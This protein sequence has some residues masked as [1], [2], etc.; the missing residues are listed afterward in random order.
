MI[1]AI[2][3][4]GLLVG[5][6]GENPATPETSGEAAASS[7]DGALLEKTWQLRMADA[8][9]RDRFESDPGWGNTFKRDYSRGLS[10]FGE[11]AGKARMHLEYA[12]LYRQALLMYAHA[13]HHVY[14]ETR[15]PTDPI[16]VD[17]L[18]GISRWVR[19]D[20]GMGEAFGA[21][22]ESTDA[23]ILARASAWST[24]TVWPPELTGATFPDMPP[25][26]SPGDNPGLDSLPHYAMPEQSERA[27]TIDTA[28]PT[29]LYHLA[30]WHEQAAVQLVGE[31]GEALISQLLAP[32]RLPVEPAPNAELLP[33]DDAW[34]FAST[35]LTAPED[36]AFLADASVR[37][38]AAVEQWKTESPLA[39]ALV[40]S[41]VD[42]AVVPDLVLDQGAEFRAAVLDTMKARSGSTEDFQITFAWMA[43][44]AVFRAGMVVADANDQYRDAGIL[45]INALEQ[46]DAM[47]AS[48]NLAKDPVFALSVAAWD[49]G[50]R[51]PVRAQQLVHE[52]LGRFPSLTA[53]R[54]PL[55]ALN[56]RAS[57]NAGPSLIAN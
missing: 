4:A 29:A 34:L 26:V 37:G 21:L 23:D 9:Q 57:R 14:G 25:E 15:E 36:A 54:Y 42:G 32:Y 43:R 33:I 47:K 5:C 49:A 40:P 41:I 19:G 48:L 28:D 18:L 11:D 10:S 17:Y 8:T 7:I 44:I 53:A 39:S 13:T 45:R 38:L 12:A 35:A 20:E 55:D 30:R 50:N 31:G 46:M 27:L 24:A 16:A 22:P 1:Y 6:T 51:N 3:M 2:A 52:L 56:I